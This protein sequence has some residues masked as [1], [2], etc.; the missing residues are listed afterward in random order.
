MVNGAKEG[1]H[2]LARRLQGGPFRILVESL[3]TK[4]ERRTED[5]IFACISLNTDYIEVHL[6]IENISYSDIFL[7][8]ESRSDHSL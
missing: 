8:A 4:T 5:A 6:F 2:A 1:L 3:P 7:A